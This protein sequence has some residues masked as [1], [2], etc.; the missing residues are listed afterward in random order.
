M[1]NVILIGNLTRDP[2]YRESGNGVC[3]FS[4]AIKE[5]EQVSYP[6]V[7][8]FGKQAENCKKYLSK[9]SKVGVQGRI[10]TGSYEKNGQKVY[11]TEVIAFRVEFLST[12]PKEEREESIEDNFTQ[13]T[14]DD[15]PF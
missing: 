9:G 7:V 15:V 14:F 6:T 12:K 1:N 13:P 10:Q 2:E 3:K 11:T 4:V 8:V 5:G